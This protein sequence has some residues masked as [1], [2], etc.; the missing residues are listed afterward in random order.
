MSYPWVVSVAN[1]LPEPFASVDMSPTDV[2]EEPNQ[3]PALTGGPARSEPEDGP[4]THYTDPSLRD[5]LLKIVNFK[6]KFP[7]GEITEC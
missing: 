6:V 2:V 7:L 5:E 3:D 4:G 1:P